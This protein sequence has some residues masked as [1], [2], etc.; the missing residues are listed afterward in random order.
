MEYLNGGDLYSLLRNLGCL[1]E[2]MARTYM[3]ELVSYECLLFP[4]SILQTTK[5]ERSI[6]S[7]SFILKV[8]IVGIFISICRFLL[9]SICIL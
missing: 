9:W 8:L 5:S 3:A 7:H 6:L 2:D 1:D 4:E